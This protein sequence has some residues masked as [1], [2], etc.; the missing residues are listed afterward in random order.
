[1]EQ[2][3]PIAGGVLRPTLRLYLGLGLANL[4]CWAGALAAFWDRPALLGTAALAYSFGL[5]HAVDADHIAAIDNATRKL[6]QEGKRPLKVGLFFSLGHSTVVV[7]LTVAVALAAT[8]VQRHF[9]ALEGIGGVLGTL[10][11]AGFL[12]ALALVNLA[13]LV[14]L[15][16]AW[17][18]HRAGGSLDEAGIGALLARR[19]L[20]GRL[21][22]RLF[23]LVRAD[24]QMYLVGLLFGLGF[25]TATE[26]GLLGVTAA[27]ASKG[28]AIWSILLFP[29]LFTAGMTLID[30]SDSVL[31][32]GAY[33]WAFAEPG[34]K[35]FYNIAI[36]ALSVGVALGIGAVEVLGMLQNDAGPA[37]PLWRGIAILNDHFGEIGYGIVAMFLAGW[38]LSFS[39][40]RLRRGTRLAA[41]DEPG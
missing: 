12:L 15:L 9:P 20:L 7:A 3:L 37:R 22:R 4:L 29:A 26:I 27:E 39:L 23:A 24:W 33:G 14:A 8:Q 32:T 18:R 17:R 10:L 6:M 5:R 38:G 31:M 28:L 21:F 2:D 25:D 40:Y 1:M 19:G 35:L 11:S 34:R 41:F 16:R 36:T 30:T 13:I